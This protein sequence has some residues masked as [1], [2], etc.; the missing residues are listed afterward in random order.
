MPTAL[1]TVVSTLGK[2]QINSLRTLQN[3]V[4]SGHSHVTHLVVSDAQMRALQAAY[5]AAKASGLVIDP[6]A[7]AAARQLGLK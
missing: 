6:K 1:Q 4:E 5:D 2:R 7:V 3:K